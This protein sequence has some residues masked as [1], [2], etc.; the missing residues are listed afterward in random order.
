MRFGRYIIL[1]GRQGFYQTRMPITVRRWW[2]FWL[3][4][5]SRLDDD[6]KNQKFPLGTQIHIE[7]RTYHYCKAA[8]DIYPKTLAE[9]E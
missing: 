5:E 1:F 7:G 8:E 9:E 2:W 3:L 6:D 4:R